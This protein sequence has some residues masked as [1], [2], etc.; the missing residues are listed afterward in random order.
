MAKTETLPHYL[1]TAKISEVAETT[2]EYSMPTIVPTDVSTAVV[3][4]KEVLIK[5]VQEDY[6]EKK[7]QSGPLGDEEEELDHSHP[8]IAPSTTDVVGLEEGSLFLVNPWTRFGRSI[9]INSK[10][11]P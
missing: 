1:Y 9:K 4:K 8:N 2:E 6:N 7:D 10:F 11:I 3:S 5:E